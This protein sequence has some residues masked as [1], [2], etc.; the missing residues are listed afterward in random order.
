MADARFEFEV[1]WTNERGKETLFISCL[2]QRWIAETIASRI[3]AD[4]KVSARVEMRRT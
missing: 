4:F 3:R 1:W 2:D